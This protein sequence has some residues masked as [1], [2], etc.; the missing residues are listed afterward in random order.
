M[1]MECPAG[2]SWNGWP[3]DVECAVED[4]ELD[5]PVEDPQRLVVGDMLLGLRREDVG[6]QQ[7]GRGVGHGMAFRT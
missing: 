6:Q 1:F 2:C 5:E 7:M 4:R 3:D